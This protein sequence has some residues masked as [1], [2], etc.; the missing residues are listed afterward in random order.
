MTT[1]QTSCI[2]R[3]ICSRQ[4]TENIMYESSLL[5]SEWRQYLASTLHGCSLVSSNQSFNIPFSFTGQGKSYCHSRS[6]AS[7]VTVDSPSILEERFMFFVKA[8]L[9]ICAGIVSKPLL[10][11]SP[12]QS[13]IKQLLL[14]ISI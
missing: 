4:L 5:R 7:G 3:I 2:F 10:S 8:K 11:L 14:K 12:C 6:F 1:E 13:T 9:L